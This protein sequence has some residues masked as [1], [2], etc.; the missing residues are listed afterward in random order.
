MALNDYN[1]LLVSVPR[2]LNKRNLD[3]M[4]GDFI[5]LT[6]SDLQSKLRTREMQTTVDAPV[7]CASV[8]LPIDWLDATRLWMDGAIRSLDYCTVDALEEIRAQGCPG[9]G[10]THF[11]WTDST[12]ELAPVPASEL[13][14]HMAYYRRIPTLSVAAPT[15]WLTTRDIGCYLYGALVR[16]SP[17]L[18]DDSRVATW[19][20]EYN[21][22][23]AALNVS[24]QV[25]LHSGAPL[26][27]R[28][29]G[30][31]RGVDPRPWS[32]T[33]GGQYS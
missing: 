27:R 4:A 7:S 11:S 25:A 31:G 32:A 8:N 6:E 9:A 14:L 18:L 19:T 24:S 1:D 15:N 21:S 2:W 28:I 26:K 17:Y 3:G 16:A 5:K 10:P 20:A 23:V 30:Y 29:R 13:I 22:R 12:I 33:A